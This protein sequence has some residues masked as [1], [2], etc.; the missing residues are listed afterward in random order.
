MTKELNYKLRFPR[1]TALV[2]HSLHANMS[3]GTIKAHLHNGDFIM[4]N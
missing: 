2:L 3:E 1:G 4:M